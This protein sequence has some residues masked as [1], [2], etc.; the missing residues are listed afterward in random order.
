MPRIIVQTEGTLQHSPAATLSERL[1]PA[2][3]R[4]DYYLDQLME[5]I[6]WALLDAEELEAANASETVSRA[7]HR[8]DRV[9]DPRR[10]KAPRSARAR[11]RSAAGRSAAGPRPVASRS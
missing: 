2:E 10:A 11:G 6:G 8:R 7:T 3:A 9:V 5:R 1:V 4:T